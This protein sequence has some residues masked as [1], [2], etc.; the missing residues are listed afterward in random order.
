ML[1][2]LTLRPLLGLELRAPPTRAASGSWVAESGEP[3]QVASW[4]SGQ[5]GD[6]SLLCWLSLFFLLL[7]V[8][9]RSV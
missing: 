3:V 5:G 4:P 1:Q 9:F 7:W 6:P 8:P 2:T